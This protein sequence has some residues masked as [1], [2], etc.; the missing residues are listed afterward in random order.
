MRLQEDRFQVDL[1]NNPVLGI[2]SDPGDIFYSDYILV[3]LKLCV[4]HSHLQGL[5]KRRLLAPFPEFLFQE[6]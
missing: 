2:V 1:H 6:V 3:V 5:L 4:H